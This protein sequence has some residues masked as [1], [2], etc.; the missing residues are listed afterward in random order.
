MTADTL[1]PEVKGEF[2]KGL[3]GGLSMASP[4]TGGHVMAHEL[5]HGRLR[6]SGAGKVIAALRRPG[7]IA[8]GLGGAAMATFADP[9]SKASKYAPLVGGLGMLP[10]LA[11]EGYASL[12]G[13]GAM[14]RLG[15]GPEQLRAARRQLGKA[16]GTYATAA[17]PLIAAPYAIRKI[18]QHMQ[19]RKA[20]QGTARAE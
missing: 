1:T 20:A 7:M 5:G 9:D 17:I 10:T 11:D 13:Y 18:K 4:E 8:G 12:K 16:F 14:K 19:R 3:K 15:Y 6:E 2:Q